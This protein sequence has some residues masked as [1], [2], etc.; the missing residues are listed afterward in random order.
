MIFICHQNLLRHYRVNNHLL[1][2]EGEATMNPQSEQSPQSVNGEENYLLASATTS[3]SG[4]PTAADYV[5]RIAAVTAGIFL[6][7]TVV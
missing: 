2:C 3:E 6:L 5:Y 7:A 1:H 4:I